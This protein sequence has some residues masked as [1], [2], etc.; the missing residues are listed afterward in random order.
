MR[1]IIPP[2]LQLGDTICIIAPSKS[3]STLTNAQ[4]EAAEK[5]LIDS[6]FNVIYGK[7]VEEI[8]DFNSSSVAS[9]VA[10]FHHAF[11][12]KHVKAI[13]AAVGGFN[14][15]QLL[16]HIDWEIIQNNPKIL[17]GNSDVTTLL[18]AIYKKT[19]LVTY[20]GPNFVSFCDSEHG[21]YTVDNFKTCL[22]TG[23]PFTPQPSKRWSN[24]NCV[25]SHKITRHINEGYWIL[26]EGKS[27]GY[28]IG[29]NLITFDLLKG[30]EYFPPMKNA[31]LFLEDDY[32]NTPQDIDEHLEALII[33]EQFN[34]VQGIVFGRFQE[35]SKMTR[36]LLTEMVRTKKELKGIPIIANVDFGHTEPKITFPY[37]GKV[38]IHAAKHSAYIQFVDH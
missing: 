22:T 37:G 11:L 18:T 7:H 21:T 6:G 33:D 12:N 31:I 25:G 34:Q 4:R 9:R 29:E 1:R 36:E 30:T 5:R 24:H 8:D 26:Q 16:R 13:V 15:N 17:C 2:R 3:I 38:K 20:S 14:A 23:E 32:N 27:E 35:Q 19:G 10:D 28:A